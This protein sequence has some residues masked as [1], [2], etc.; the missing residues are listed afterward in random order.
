MKMDLSACETQLRLAERVKRSKKCAQFEMVGLGKNVERT[1]E[2]S[3]QTERRPQLFSKSE[4]G[5]SVLLPEKGEFVEGKLKRKLGPVGQGAGASVICQ[6]Q[7]AKNL[8]LR[9]QET[10]LR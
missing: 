2:S 4:S 5:C 7:E 6:K 10:L 8:P 3:K 9:W 1:L